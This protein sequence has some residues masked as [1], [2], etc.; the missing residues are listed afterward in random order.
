LYCAAAEGVRAGRAL[1]ETTVACPGH[2]LASRVPGAVRSENRLNL[3]CLKRFARRKCLRWL[4]NV[5]QIVES[6]TRAVAW[7]MRQHSVSSARSSNRT[8]PCS[9]SGGSRSRAEN[10]ERAWVPMNCGS[11][12]RIDSFYQRAPRARG[13]DSLGSL[14]NRFP[15]N[16]PNVEPNMM[17][18]TRAR[19]APTM[20]T[21][22]MSR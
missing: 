3:W 17:T 20:A 22:T 9:A 12:R 6:R 7:A 18:A 8:G 2:H 19:I 4:R 10:P 5:N 11:L 21:M 1:R 16:D 13:R 15:Q 14:S